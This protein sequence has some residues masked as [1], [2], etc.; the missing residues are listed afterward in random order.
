MS[1]ATRGE[2]RQLPR[3][4]HRE[5]LIR[6]TALYPAFCTALT[7]IVYRAHGLLL[8]G[9]DSRSL[10]GEHILQSSPGWPRFV[11]PPG[12]Y[13]FGVVPVLFVTILWLIGRPT[14]DVPKAHL[15]VPAL[16]LDAGMTG[17]ISGSFLDVEPWPHDLWIGAVFM[18]AC[19]VVVM[20]VAA[21]RRRRRRQR[22]RRP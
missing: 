8:A 17:V 6:A 22:E 4:S 21:R 9:F 20:V 2:V 14:R 13:W 5:A 7:I 19:A 18:A 3:W 12:I 10:Y 11:V 1:R 16:L 15:L